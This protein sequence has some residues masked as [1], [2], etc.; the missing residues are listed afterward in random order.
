M[1]QGFGSRCCLTE[2][3]RTYRLHGLSYD[4]WQRHRT[5]EAVASE[6]VAAGFKYNMT[7]LQ[8]SLGLP[9]LNKLER[10][11]QIR[12]NLASMYDE[13]LANVEE[14]RHQPRPL[15]GYPY[16]IPILQLHSAPVHADPA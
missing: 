6:V 13:G 11:L 5:K 1:R 10:F 15:P 7:D 12:E 4:A 14:V 9:Q 3:I 16:R 8:A 2:R